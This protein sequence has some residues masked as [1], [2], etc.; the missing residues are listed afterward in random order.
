MADEN[1]NI[2]R[3]K[4]NDAPDAQVDETE[5]T[6][7]TTTK[8]DTDS[9]SDSGSNAAADN[10]ARFT[11]LEATLEK[12][13]GEISAIREAQGIM[14]ENGAVITDTDADLDF[15]DADSFVPPAELDLLI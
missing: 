2:S 15:T 8:I 6:T 9:G 13:L 7:E 10:E 11:R 3:D 5:E 12:V 14:V 1:D 4:E